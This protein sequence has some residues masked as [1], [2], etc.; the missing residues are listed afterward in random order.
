MEIFYTP[1]WILFFHLLK[2]LDGDYISVHRTLFF[3]MAAPQFNWP[4]DENLNCSS[5]YA[6]TNNAEINSH[7]LLYV[8]VY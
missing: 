3:S 2:Y 4:L 5:T 7:I 1:F 6:M 8:P